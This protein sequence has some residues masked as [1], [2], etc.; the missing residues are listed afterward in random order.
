MT[1]NPITLANQLQSYG[2]EGYRYAY[3]RKGQSIADEGTFSLT[4]ALTNPNSDKNAFG[5]NL[6]WMLKE[7]LLK[8]VNASQIGTSDYVANYQRTGNESLESLI[9]KYGGDKLKSTVVQK[10][11]EYA[12]II[13]NE[14]GTVV[15]TDEWKVKKGPMDW[16]TPIFKTG[17]IGTI[18]AATG[19]AASAAVGGGFAGSVAGGAATGATGATIT[20]NDILKGA[21]IGA[22]TGGVAKTISPAV[23]NALTPTIGK[24]AAGI[25]AKG[26]TGGVNAL[27]KGGDFLTGVISGS[28]PSLD[29]GNRFINTPLNSLFKNSVMNLIGLNKQTQS[30]RP[31]T[32]NQTPSRSISTPQQGQLV[33]LIRSIYSQRRG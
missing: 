5:G 13:S 20:G 1:T 6:E 30:P 14:A 27:V 18:A 23:S 11:N 19:G 4:A 24:T 8:D 21:L 9:T 26:T 31:G 3:D 33:N 10:G 25:V 2:Q 22:F 7:G 29:F 16:F 17:V 32:G 12:R 15:D 28:I